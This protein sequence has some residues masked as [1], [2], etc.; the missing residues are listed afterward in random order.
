MKTFALIHRSSPEN[1]VIGC[2]KPALLYKSD[3]KPKRTDIIDWLKFHYLNGIRVRVG[4]QLVCESCGGAFML[5]AD[6]F[7]EYENDIFG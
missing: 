3:S 5:D 2:D 6:F 7:E 4:E 1:N